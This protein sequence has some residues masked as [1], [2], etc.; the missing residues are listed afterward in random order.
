MRTKAWALAME[1]E[2]QKLR[3]VAERIF[4]HIENDLGVRSL[5]LD[6]DYYWQIP[7]AE[8]YSVDK[9]P[10]ELD[11]GQLSEDL[12]FLEDVVS[13]REQAVSL[14]FLHLAPLLRYLA[15]KVGQ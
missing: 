10:P 1:I 3:L 13:D 5:P 14:M 11:I 12:S 8:L 6:N 15:I 4:N 7:D 2:V 9:D